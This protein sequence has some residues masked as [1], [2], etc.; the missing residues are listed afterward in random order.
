MRKSTAQTFRMVAGLD[1]GDRYSQFCILDPDGEVVE[2][3]RIATTQQALRRKFEGA[4]PMLV[5]SEVGTHSPWVDRLLRSLGHETIVANAGKVYEFTETGMSTKELVVIMGMGGVA[6][7]G[8]A[9]T[10]VPVPAS[11]T[12][13][14]IRAVRPDRSNRRC[15]R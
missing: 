6:L 11:T 15:G 10:G 9:R 3:G 13:S 5:V 1:L 2:E 8:R 4:E 14:T 7:A 12:P